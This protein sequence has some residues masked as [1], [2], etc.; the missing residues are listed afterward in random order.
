VNVIARD[1]SIDIPQ[2]MN[3]FRFLKAHYLKLLN[4]AEVTESST[5]HPPG[6]QSGGRSLRPKGWQTHRQV[7]YNTLPSEVSPTETPEDAQ[8]AAA[9]FEQLSTFT[10]E[11]DALIW[12]TYVTHTRSVAASKDMRFNA[13]EGTV[14]RLAESMGRMGG[15]GI[16]IVLNR[17]RDLKKKRMELGLDPAQPFPS[18][19]TATASTS[20]A[21]TADDASEIEESSTL[22]NTTSNETSQAVNCPDKSTSTAT[23]SP[24]SKAFTVADDDVIWNKYLQCRTSQSPS[25]KTSIEGLDEATTKELSDALGQTVGDVI[26]RFKHIV[27]ARSS[28]ED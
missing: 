21:N 14:G 12:T 23:A 16:Q 20:R 18:P 7:M 1:L 25:T 5:S 26:V 27:V 19:A 17:F 13:P 4:G 22:M 15:S 2:L 8:E 24:A 28:S 11:E 10:A 9:L 6:E 3:R